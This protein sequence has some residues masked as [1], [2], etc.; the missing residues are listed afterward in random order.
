MGDRDAP[1]LR[2]LDRRCRGPGTERSV[3]RADRWASKENRRFDIRSGRG[4]RDLRLQ[5]ANS[6]NAIPPTAFLLSEFRLLS[7]VRGEKTYL[8]VLRG[9]DRPAFDRALMA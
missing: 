3:A 4:A 9:K 5:P 7:I 2:G 1:F 6:S 8:E